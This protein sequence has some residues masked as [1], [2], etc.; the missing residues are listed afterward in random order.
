MVKQDG[1]EWVANT[2]GLEP[3]WTR[4]PDVAN[5]E[6]LARRYFN[7]APS[8]PCTVTFHA[9]GAFNKLYKVET[10]AR[11]AL[12]R[13]TLPVDPSY[14]TD[15]E[16]ATINFVR[17]KTDMP[18]PKIFA[19][20][21]SSE[22]ALGFEWILMEMLPGRTLRSKWRKIPGDVKRNLVK[23]I[24][25]YQAQLFRRRFSAIGHLFSQFGASSTAKE[26]LL[27]IN[28]PAIPESQ[29]AAIA[30]SGFLLGQL[31]SMIFFWGDHISQDVPRGP[32]IK[33]EDWIKSRLTLILADQVKIL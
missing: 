2:F 3:R 29:Q 24:A 5:I 14:K 4:E 21:M 8:F 7:V 13:V 6:L 16:V 23:Q 18:V 26:A 31:V 15:S 10:K 22:N 30:S 12:M 28:L 11:C 9:Q 20:D 19:F 32:F 27:Q 1:L 33:S 17:Q 25:K